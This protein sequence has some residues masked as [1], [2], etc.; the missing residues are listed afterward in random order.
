[1]KK[2]L[3]PAGTGRSNCSVQTL[4]QTALREMAL[5]RNGQLLAAWSLRLQAVSVCCAPAAV[6]QLKSGLPSHNLFL[7]FFSRERKAGM[8]GC[9]GWAEGHTGCAQCHNRIAPEGAGRDRDA[10]L[11]SQG[12]FPIPG[13]TLALTIVQLVLVLLKVS[14]SP[15]NKEIALVGVWI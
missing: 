8:P 14:A 3:K 9:C 13:R 4:V 15:A 5:Y 7:F 12:T 2:I 11:L 1:M 10:V 6:G